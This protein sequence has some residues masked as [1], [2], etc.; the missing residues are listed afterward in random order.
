MAWE[1]GKSSEGGYGA[2]QKAVQEAVEAGYRLIDCAAV[3]G[4]EQGIG[5]ALTELFQSNT[6]DR[7]EVFVVSKIFNNSHVVNG[8]DRPRHALKKSRQ[9]LQLDILLMHWPL[10]FLDR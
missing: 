2:G 3:Y 4:S 8:E 9:D 6:I 5:R 7:S 10:A 1:P